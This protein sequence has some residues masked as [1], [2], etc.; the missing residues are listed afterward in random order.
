MSCFNLNRGF[1]FHIKGGFRLIYNVINQAGIS[2]EL[3]YLLDF[4]VLFLL[5]LLD[6][7]VYNLSLSDSKN[8]VLCYN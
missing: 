3:S 4:L 2:G 5:L 8:I 7:F 1:Y 6:L